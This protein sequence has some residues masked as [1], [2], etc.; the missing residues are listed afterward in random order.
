MKRDEIWP[1]RGR[2]PRCLD[3]G[4]PERTDMRNSAFPHPPTLSHLTGTI[5]HGSH[6]IN[7]QLDLYNCIIW[8]GYPRISPSIHFFSLRWWSMLNVVTIEICSHS[9]PAGDWQQSTSSSNTN[10]YE[11]RLNLERLFLIRSKVF[12]PLLRYRVA[13][14]HY[15]VLVPKQMEFQ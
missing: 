6:F 12:Y 15:K 7:T 2:G 14:V 9:Q 10:Q 5:R 3:R 8:H 1:T 11:D 4:G 13:Q